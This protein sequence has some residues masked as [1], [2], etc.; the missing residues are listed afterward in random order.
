[1][2]RYCFDTSGLSNPMQ[3][4][5]ED[6]YQSIWVQVTALIEAGHIAV[7]TEI[8][9]EMVH[10]PGIVG[11]CITD[12]P[13][14]LVMEVMA[15]GWDWEAYARHISDL[16]VRYEA[17]IS[18]RQGDRKRTIGLNDMSIIALAKTLGLPVVSMETPAG[19]SAETR[20]KIPDICYEEQIEHIDFNEFLR[21]EGIRST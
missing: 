16:Q 20:R 19:I 6:I 15:A 8:Y 2:K 10:I 12:N 21:R 5:P 4:L 1:M 13:R 3:L 7:S 11:A 14:A 18:E 9:D 17:F